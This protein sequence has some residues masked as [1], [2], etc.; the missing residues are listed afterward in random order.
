MAMNLF[1]LLYDADALEDLNVLSI[2]ALPHI[3]ITP[4]RAGYLHLC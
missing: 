3:L 4:L 1:L 2:S